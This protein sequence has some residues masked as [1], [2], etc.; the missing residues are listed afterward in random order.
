MAPR[1]SAEEIRSEQQE[2]ERRRAEATSKKERIKASLVENVGEQFYQFS[3]EYWSGLLQDVETVTSEYFLGQKR[4][5]LICRASETSL[6][7]SRLYQARSTPGKSLGTSV[8]PD[9][10]LSNEEKP[11]IDP[12]FWFSLLWPEE[13]IVQMLCGNTNIYEELHR[14]EG[15]ASSRDWTPVDTGDMYIWISLVIYMG[16]YEV[17]GN[18]SE[19]WDTNP[20]APKYPPMQHMSRNRFQQ[21]KRYLHVSNPREETQYWYEKVKP[22]TDV[23]LAYSRRYYVPSSHV[24]VDEMMVEFEGRSKDKTLNTSKSI[25]ESYELFVICDRGFTIDLIYSSGSQ[26]QPQ[27][28]LWQDLDLHNDTNALVY[29]L[30]L[31]LPFR[32]FHFDIVM[33]NKFSSVVLFSRLRELRIGACG[34]ART[35]Y[36]FFPR[37]WK[38]VKTDHPGITLEVLGWEG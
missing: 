12:E 2:K 9:L 23:I 27:V 15:S 36:K 11:P 28:F 34:T 17:S 22:V 6:E 5:L 16:V 1:R 7:S 29:Y 37:E 35:G 21:I 14:N 10:P 13:E 32:E 26:G 3:D 20:Q 4:L 18:I 8:C 38:G 25:P 33:D 30:A 19:Y 31:A 24:S